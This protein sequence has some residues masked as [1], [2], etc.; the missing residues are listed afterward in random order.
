M[1]SW[2]GLVALAGT[3]KPAIDKIQVVAIYTD[4]AVV[5]RLDKAGIN[6]VTSTP[7]EFDALFRNEARRWTKVFRDSG[8]RLE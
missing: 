1:S 5:D 7:A 2:I 4:P 8:V 6:P 3:P